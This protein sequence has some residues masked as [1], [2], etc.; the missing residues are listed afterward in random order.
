MK[1]VLDKA[2]CRKLV[3]VK[4]DDLEKSM[5]SLDLSWPEMESHFGSE[6]AEIAETE[7]ICYGLCS[8]AEPSMVG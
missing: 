4:R 3:E 7:I 5:I 1:A 6:S 8:Q 2:S